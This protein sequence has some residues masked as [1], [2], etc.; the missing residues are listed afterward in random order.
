MT[1]APED[2]TPAHHRHPRDRIVSVLDDWLG[3]LTDTQHRETTIAAVLAADAGHAPDPPEVHAARRALRDLPMEFDRVL[4][5]I[6]A[7]MDPDL[8]VVTTKQSQRDLA[9]AEATITA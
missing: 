1:E 9:A 7:G 6:R 2:L 5:A 8:A 4:A 3:Q